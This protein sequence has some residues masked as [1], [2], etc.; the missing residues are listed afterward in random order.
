MWLHIKNELKWWHRLVDD[1]LTG[2]L[3]TGIWR[4][5]FDDFDISSF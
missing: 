1:L 3:I 2:E 4:V 5:S